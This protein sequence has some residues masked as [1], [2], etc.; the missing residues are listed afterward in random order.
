MMKQKRMEILRQGLDLARSTGLEIGPLAA[1]I[2]RKSEGDVIYVDHA[3]TEEL[4]AKYSAD[5]NIDPACIVPV[6][7][8]WGDQTLA[9][10][11]GGRKVDYIIAS[12]VSEHVPDLVTWLQETHAVLKP[13]GQLRLVLPDKRFSFDYL[14]DETRI[15][16]LLT[17]YLLR[18]RRPQVRDVLDFRLHFAPRMDGWGEY[19]GVFDPST[20]KP[21]ASFEEAMGAARYVLENEIYHDVHCWV[22][23]PRTF[24]SLM[25]KLAGYGLL[26]LECAGMVDSSVPLLEFYVFMQPCNDRARVIESWRDA[27]NTLR[28]PLPG[29]GAEAALLADAESALRT[30]DELEAARRRI[31]TLENSRSWKLTAPLRRMKAMMG[32]VDRARAKVVQE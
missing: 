6:D 23:T 10:C 4:L 31:R 14:R 18:A 2:V 17:A 12:H 22:F 16:D 25:E 3:S 9:E 8:V 32:H 13:N 27:R 5:P 24:A 19:K 15:S 30:D 20:L 21:L 28:D 1:P 11:I 26:P 7:A 29:S